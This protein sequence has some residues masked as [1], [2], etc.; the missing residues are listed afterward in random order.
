MKRMQRE[1]I[2]ARIEAKI[3]EK[4]AEK[5]IATPKRLAWER[6]IAELRSADDIPAATMRVRLRGV[7]LHDLETMADRDE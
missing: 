4:L 7:T 6:V 1:R 3:V 2:A 5:T